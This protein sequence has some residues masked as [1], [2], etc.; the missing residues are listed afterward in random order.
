MGTRNPLSPSHFYKAWFLLLPCP[1]LSKRGWLGVRA[2][3]W[4]T[5]KKKQKK[6]KKKKKKKKPINN[7]I[8]TVPATDVELLKL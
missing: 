8:P 6:K 3:G 1:A 5:Q 7:I 4:T 2:E